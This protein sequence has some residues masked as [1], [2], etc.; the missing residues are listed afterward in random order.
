M[1]DVEEGKTMAII[2]YI[3]WIGLIIAVVMNQDKKNEFAKFHIRQSLLL[4]LVSLIA[5]IPIIG[6]ILGVLAFIAWVIGLINA[7]QGEAKEVFLFGTYAQ[8]WFKGI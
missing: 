2:A 1:K 5:W 8:E 3:T 4:M 7:I 6:W